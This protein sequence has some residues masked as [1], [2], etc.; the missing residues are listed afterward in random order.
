MEPAEIAKL[1][2]TLDLLWQRFLPQMLERIALLETAATGCRNATL[3]EAQIRAAHNA[4]HNLAG[5]LGTFDLTRGSV[6]A[7]ELEMMYSV[8][9]GPAPELAPQL[10]S[11][12]AEL[13]S[14]VE[15]RK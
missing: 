10:T 8:G 4:A 3:T 5:S 7:R 13:Q 12:A 2:A 14:I 6:L 1:A 9:D 11:L 15:S